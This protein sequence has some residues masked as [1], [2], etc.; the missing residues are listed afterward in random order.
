MFKVT[1]LPIV[2]Q[3][4]NV[5]AESQV[6]LYLTLKPMHIPAPGSQFNSGKVH[7]Y[8]DS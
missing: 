8:L 1:N 6:S 5:S 7:K 3:V 4:V 2:M